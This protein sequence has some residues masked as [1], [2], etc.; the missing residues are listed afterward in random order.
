VTYEP[1]PGDQV[2]VKGTVTGVFPQGV[3]Q[4]HVGNS[5]MSAFVEP[6]DVVGPATPTA[7]DESA[8]LKSIYESRQRF[9]N[10]EIDRLRAALRVA[11]ANEEAMRETSVQAL[12]GLQNCM[13]ERDALQ[14]RIDAAFLALD[15][16]GPIED[17]DEDVRAVYAALTAPTEGDGDD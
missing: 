6:A 3:T 11:E 13:A 7:G 4:V 10:A 9:K 15:A 12:G 16:W 2:L 1:Q 5:D 8:D 14:T 17:A